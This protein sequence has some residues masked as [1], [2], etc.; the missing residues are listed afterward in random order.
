MRMKK[1]IGKNEIF[2]LTTTNVLFSADR[3]IYQRYDQIKCDKEISG[4]FYKVTAL[5]GR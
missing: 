2:Y 5:Q 4:S 3:Y 1:E